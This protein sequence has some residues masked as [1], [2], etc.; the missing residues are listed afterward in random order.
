VWHG[1]TD[2][3]ARARVGCRRSAP[4]TTR[5]RTARTSARCTAWG[6][7]CPTLGFTLLPLTDCF[8]IAALVAD[9]FADVLAR[10]LPG[11]LLVL[12]RVVVTLRGGLLLSRRSEDDLLGRRHALVEADG[13]STSCLHGNRSV[14]ELQELR[15][16][17]LGH[18]FEETVAQLAVPNDLVVGVDESGALGS[19]IQVGLARLLERNHCC[20]GLSDVALLWMEFVEG[21]I[22]DVPFDCVRVQCVSSRLELGPA[23]DSEGVGWTWV[24]GRCFHL[25]SDVRRVELGAERVD[26]ER[27]DDY[28]RRQ[29]RK[30]NEGSDDN[31]HYSSVGL[32]ERPCLHRRYCGLARIGHNHRALIAHD[33]DPLPGRFLMGM[34]QY[35]RPVANIVNGKVQVILNLSSS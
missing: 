35:S 28:E 12:A 3:L 26:H 23:S 24:R 30:N 5:C 14:G 19:G 11:V 31:R 6:G 29:C 15:S 25:P 21:I 1:A 8:G 27:Y 7:V 34:Q 10:V 32:V 20:N 2:C 33:E 4:A 22:H 13:V 16:V 18:V 9:G 17:V